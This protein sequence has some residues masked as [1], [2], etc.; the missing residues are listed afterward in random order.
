LPSDFVMPTAPFSITGN[1]FFKI[2]FNTTHGDSDLYWRIILDERGADSL[3]TPYEREI[4]VCSLHCKVET[5]SDASF[6][7]RAGTIKYHIA[8]C[9]SELQINE[10]G[11]AVLS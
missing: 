10:A 11:H 9:C 8:G 7:E 1:L 6:D 3:P 2:R 4:L 5:Y